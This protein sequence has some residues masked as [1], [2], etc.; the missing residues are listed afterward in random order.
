VA[1]RSPTFKHT[2]AAKKNGYAITLHLDSKTRSVIDEFSTSNFIAIARE[3]ASDGVSRKL[4]VPTSASILASVTTKAIIQIAEDFGWEVERRPVPFS[5][6]VEGK[7]EEV[8]ACGTAAAV[9]R[10]RGH[11]TSSKQQ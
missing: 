10:S 11:T 6:V 2:A 8:A 3:R 5:E 4:V 7:Y 9:S 1:A